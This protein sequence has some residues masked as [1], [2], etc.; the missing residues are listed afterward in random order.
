MSLSSIATEGFLQGGSVSCVATEGFLCFEALEEAV[1][2]GGGDSSGRRKRRY[3]R[4]VSTAELYRRALE[5]KEIRE[6][7]EDLPIIER[8]EIEHDIEGLVREVQWR[9]RQ[10]KAE[11]YQ[12]AATT[13]AR[14]AGELLLEIQKAQALEEMEPLLL[15]LL[16]EDL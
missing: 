9:L 8:V 6:T 13:R 4:V 1:I 3:P 5:A 15:L 7:G 12:R 10:I 2:E 16:A 11:R 14:R